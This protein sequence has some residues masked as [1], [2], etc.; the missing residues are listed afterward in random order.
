MKIGIVGS[1]RRNELEDLKLLGEFLVQLLNSVD[2]PILVSGGCKKGGDRFAE[3][4]AKEFDIPIIIH[5]PNQDDLPLDPIGKDF[6]RINHARNTL[7]ARDS[8]VLIAI[9]APDRKGGTEDTIRKFRKLNPRGEL[10][11]L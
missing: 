8:E 1:R 11:L 6:S 3:I 2:D 7:I 9:V 10:F 4:L 5:Y